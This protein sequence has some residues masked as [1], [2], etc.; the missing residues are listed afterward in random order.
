MKRHAAAACRR[1][2]AAR[3][4]GTPRGARR[5]KFAAHRRD[6]ETSMI[7]RRMLIGGAWCEAEHGATFERRDPV[8]G[9]LASRA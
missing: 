9:A 7:D 4:R 5:L 3:Q 2:R 8:T 1:R 6:K